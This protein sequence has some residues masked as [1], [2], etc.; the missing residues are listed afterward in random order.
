MEL[1]AIPLDILSLLLDQLT[2]QDIKRVR[3]VFRSLHKIAKL[4]ISRV[5]L[6]AEIQAFLYEDG[7]CP[8]TE[9]APRV[10]RVGV[11]IDVWDEGFRELWL[12]GIA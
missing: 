1:T 10:A 2:Q 8:F 5:I 6:S 7:N 12:E 3:L 11:V 9:Q 4:R